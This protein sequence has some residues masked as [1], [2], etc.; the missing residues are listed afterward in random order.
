MTLL[1][2]LSL[3]PCPI[4][5]GLAGASSGGYCE[6]DW[7][8]ADDGSLWPPLISAARPAAASLCSSVVTCPSSVSLHRRRPPPRDAAIASRLLIQAHAHAPTH[9]RRTDLDGWTALRWGSQP[10]PRRR[11]TCTNGVKGRRDRKRAVGRWVWEAKQDG[12][13][14]G[15]N[16]KRAWYRE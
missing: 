5:K 10:A 8:A 2:L 11:S 14:G 12:D 13:V 7:V 1:L 3:R 6:I 15:A 9:R 16:S 4:Y